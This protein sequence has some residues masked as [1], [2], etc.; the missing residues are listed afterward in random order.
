MRCFA[1]RHIMFSDFNNRFIN[2]HF[3]ELQYNVN[4]TI[5][6]KFLKINGKFNH[7]YIISIIYLFTV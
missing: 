4:I 2:K 6:C 5:I 7:T 3:F 1:L